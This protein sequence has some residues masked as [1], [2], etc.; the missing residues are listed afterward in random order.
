MCAICP[1]GP[2][3]GTPEPSPGLNLCRQP[4]RALRVLPRAVLRRLHAM[5][6]RMVGS[7]SQSTS[8]NAFKEFSWI[9]LCLPRGK[10]SSVDHD[11]TIARYDWYNVPWQRTKRQAAQGKI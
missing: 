6:Q 11:I 10:K 2:W 8:E 9:I 4:G 7:G 3:H 5:R 1:V